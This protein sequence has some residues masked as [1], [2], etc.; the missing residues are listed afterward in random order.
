VRRPQN[1]AERLTLRASFI[2]KGARPILE[3]ENGSALYVYDVGATL[4]AVAFW[5]TS[6]KPHFHYRYPTAER[7][8]DAILQFKDAVQTHVARRTE[9]RAT[10][11]AWINP[12]K[13]GDLL[14]TSWGYDQTN[15]EFY[16]VTH[17]SGRRV[18]VRQIASDYEATGHMSGRTWPAMPI[19]FI[20]PES[21]HVAQPCGTSAS[22][23]IHNSAYAQLVTGR[24]VYTSSYA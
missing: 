6:A 23:K 1:A 2:P 13:V 18:K 15:V 16:A 24:D 7:R 14:Y 10:K 8:T 19:R 4:Y 9:Q 17:V 11:A 3:H 21:V 22:V 20:G 12:L 5:G